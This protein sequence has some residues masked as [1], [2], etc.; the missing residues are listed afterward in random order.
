M[1][2]SDRW[3]L[4]LNELDF[5]QLVICVITYEC[6]SLNLRICDNADTRTITSHHTQQPDSVAI[7][8]IPNVHL[9]AS[10]TLVESSTQRHLWKW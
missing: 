9:S 7:D 6:Y 3:F 2:R 10:L 1:R 8:E 4:C 5:D